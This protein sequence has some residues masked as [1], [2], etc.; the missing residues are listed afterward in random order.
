MR[1]NSP[2]VLHHRLITFF[3][4]MDRLIIPFKPSGV[5]RRNY[6]RDETNIPDP[7]F[8]SCRVPGA[9]QAVATTAFF[10][11]KA[12]AILNPTSLFPI[13]DCLL[14]STNATQT[15]A[16]GR[17]ISVESAVQSFR[18]LSHLRKPR[19]TGPLQLIIKRVG[20]FERS[21]FKRWPRLLYCDFEHGAVHLYI[22]ENSLRPR[23][24]MTRRIFIYSI[25]S[26]GLPR[27]TTPP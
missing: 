16:E 20:R 11:L 13:S 23:E 7:E 12:N 1:R 15:K 26:G 6:K 19:N 14:G 18:C 25:V 24:I 5:R 21:V 27:L 2:F 3:R 22:T 4:L 8:S 10:W 17:Y 9:A